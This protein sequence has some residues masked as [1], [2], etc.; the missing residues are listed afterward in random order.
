MM[1]LQGM[2][3]MG[4]GDGGWGFLACCGVCPEEMDSGERNLG[5]PMS[6]FGGSDVR[7]A[8]PKSMRRTCGRRAQRGWRTT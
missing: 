5:V 7:M 8:E 1:M 4:L 3:E 6:S 2:R